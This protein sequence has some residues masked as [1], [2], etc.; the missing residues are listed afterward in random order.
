MGLNW[1][2]WA[3]G[4]ILLLLL[5]RAEADLS[6]RKDSQQRPGACAGGPTALRLQAV[7]IQKQTAPH[8]I[9]PKGIGET[10]MAQQIVVQAKSGLFSIASL[11][12]TRKRCAHTDFECSLL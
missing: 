11:F 4:G 7:A 12:A 10:Q 5:G 1:G 3:L 8:S 6:R 9:R 2:L